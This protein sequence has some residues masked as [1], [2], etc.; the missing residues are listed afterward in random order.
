MLSLLNRT[1]SA[2]RRWS[3]RGLV[4][5]DGRLPAS[6]CLGSTRRIT[7]KSRLFVRLP[8]RNVEGREA[9][10]A[11]EEAVADFVLDPEATTGGEAAP[12][13]AE[14]AAEVALPPAAGISPVVRPPS[15]RQYSRA[16]LVLRL[17]NRS[18]SRKAFPK[19]R[20]VVAGASLGVALV[21]SLR[22]MRCQRISAC[23]NDRN[24]PS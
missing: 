7:K 14:V 5:Q 17:Q 19:V 13:A 8:R 21:R 2:S 18:P 15:V 12:G 9:A 23:H 22:N 20:N 3:R 11:V 6:T 1:T 24:T 4:S 10:A 16:V